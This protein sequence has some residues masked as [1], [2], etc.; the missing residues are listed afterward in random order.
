MHGVHSRVAPQDSLPALPD[1]MT[2][3]LVP[4]P[5]LLL[6]LLSAR[7]R[8][9]LLSPSPNPAPFLPAR[10]KSGPPPPLCLSWAPAC[11]SPAQ[12]THGRLQPASSGPFL[13]APALSLVL[14]RAAMC[15]PQQN[16]SFGE[17]RRFPLNIAAQTYT[18]T[19]TLSI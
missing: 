1:P 17:C 4:L 11:T 12:N 10:A 15:S 14:S 7:L 13:P 3:F 19:R 6:L 16:S 8:P 5:P 9:L 2:Y 18:Q